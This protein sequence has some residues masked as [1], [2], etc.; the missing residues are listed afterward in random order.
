MTIS[1]PAIG[2]LHHLDAIVPGAHGGIRALV[3]LH[4]TQGDNTLVGAEVIKLVQNKL[5]KEKTWC[6]AHF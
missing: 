5:F 6:Y 3:V 4:I 1:G 2:R